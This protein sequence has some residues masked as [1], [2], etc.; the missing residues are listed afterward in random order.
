MKRQEYGHVA[1]EIQYTPADAKN[2]LECK[3]K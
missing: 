3:K 1:A 2:S